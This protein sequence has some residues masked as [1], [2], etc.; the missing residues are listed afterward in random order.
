MTLRTSMLGV[1]GKFCG[2]VDPAF[3][4]QGDQGTDMAENKMARS[5]PWVILHVRI[6]GLLTFSNMHEIVLQCKY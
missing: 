5:P 4:R 3:V 2:R 1:A 6:R